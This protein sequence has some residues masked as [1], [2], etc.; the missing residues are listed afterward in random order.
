VVRLLLLGGTAEARALASRL[1]PDVQVVSSLAGRVPDPAL[2]V[3]EVRIGGFGGVEGLQ[4]WL[5][6][7]PVDAV[8]DATHPFA[9]T[10]TTNAAKACRELGLPHLLLARPAW[11]HG[12]SIVV[13]SDTV[14][15]KVVAGN[16]YSRVFLTTGRSGVSAF[17]RL[18]AWFLIRAV[19]PPD[20]DVM[21]L[22][23]QLLLSRGP[24]RYDDELNLLREHRIDALVT[25][26][27][28]GDMTRG[29]LDAAEALGVPVVMVGRPALPDGVRAVSTVAEAEAWVR[30]L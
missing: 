24:Y 26:N 28:G 23:H 30:A 9:A 3:G 16:G 20:A 29:K 22:R 6:D 25:K 21:P 4:R 12:T 15:A 11:P 27:S 7:S 17:T 14:A 19:T 13:G 2:P 18:D 5:A 10:I 8:V 1:H